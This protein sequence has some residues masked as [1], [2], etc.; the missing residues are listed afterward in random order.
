MPREP[1]APAP[2]AF[3]RAGTADRAALVEGFAEKARAYKVRV[4]RCGR[5][6]AAATIARLLGERGAVRLGDAVARA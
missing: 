6:E 1:A 4:E 3:R 5:A 2:R